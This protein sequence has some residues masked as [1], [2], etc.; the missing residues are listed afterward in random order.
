MRLLLQFTLLTLTLSQ[1]TVQAP[2]RGI[3]AKLAL[4]LPKE[5]DLTAI[6]LQDLLIKRPQ[7]VKAN[8]E[9]LFDQHFSLH[10]D[11][12]ALDNLHGENLVREVAK[13]RNDMYDNALAKRRFRLA[14]EKYLGSRN[15]SQEER[16]AI[17][18]RFAMQNRQYSNTV[19]RKKFVQKRPEHFKKMK[20][21]QEAVRRLERSLDFTPIGHFEQQMIL[22]NIP[23]NSSAKEIE[24][25]SRKFGYPSRQMATAHLK[26]Y[27]NSRFNEVDAA[28]AS[29]NRSS[30]NRNVSTRQKPIAMQAQHEFDHIASHSGQQDTEHVSEPYVVPVDHLASGSSTPYESSSRPASDFGEWNQIDVDNWANYFHNLDS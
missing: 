17:E 30:L 12:K 7:Y 24:E 9:P 26:L 14:I 1:S 13:L 6:T 22:H 27:L 5:A 10:D 28:E 11:V 19:S 29:A 2:V 16:Q 15:I 21:K 4:Q 20:A 25:K 23:Y 8:C 3:K 18:D